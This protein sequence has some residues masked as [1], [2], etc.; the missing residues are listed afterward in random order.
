MGF[1]F[2]LHLFTTEL[3]VYMTCD[4]IQSKNIS[5]TVTMCKNITGFRA[6]I[7]RTVT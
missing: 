1:F 2:N 7:G 5:K 4:K 6:P 3:H